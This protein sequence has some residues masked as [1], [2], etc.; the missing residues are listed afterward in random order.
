MISCKIFAAD[1][2]SIT[3]SKDYDTPSLLKLIEKPLFIMTNNNHRATN[4]CIV[5]R[6]HCAIYT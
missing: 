1:A 2:V 4:S 5:D 3:L 6:F